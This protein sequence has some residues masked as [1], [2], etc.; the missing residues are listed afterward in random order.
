MGTAKGTAQNAP[1]GRPSLPG[2]DRTTCTHG[3]HRLRQ[4]TPSGQMASR[5]L[6]ELEPRDFS[7]LPW[8]T[9]LTTT[10]KM[11]R[12]SKNQWMLQSNCCPAAPTSS[13]PPHARTTAGQ[14]LVSSRSFSTCGLLYGS[15]EDHE[16]SLPFRLGESGKGLRHC[17]HDLKACC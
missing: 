14:P 7:R 6:E 4:S 10:G 11:L 17:P 1:V 5:R 16:V 12:C 15:H 3:L 2:K 9:S 13:R 8:P